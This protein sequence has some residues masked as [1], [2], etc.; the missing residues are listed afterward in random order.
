MTEKR[1]A[2]EEERRVA[3][4]RRSAAEAQEAYKEYVRNV[5]KASQFTIFRFLPFLA[6]ILV[7][8]SVVGGGLL[9]WNTYVERKVFENS[10]QRSE[11]L[12]SSL[13]LYKASLAEIESRLS[14]PN[15]DESTRREL[16]AQVSSLKI[17]I[18]ATKEQA[19]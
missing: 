2:E 19:R 11:D 12:K 8:A 3:E 14:N 13:A 5:A 15:L 18:K 9:V 10:Y 16:E 7:F 1:S 6:I 4:E 17:R